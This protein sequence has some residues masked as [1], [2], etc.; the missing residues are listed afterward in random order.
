MGHP[1]SKGGKGPQGG[2]GDYGK[3]GHP[4]VPGHAGETVRSHTYNVSKQCVNQTLYASENLVICRDI[5]LLYVGR[6][7]STWT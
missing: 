1:G 2:K 3:P 5:V 7:W 4:G 6:G